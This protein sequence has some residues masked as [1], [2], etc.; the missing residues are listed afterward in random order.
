LN[1][2]KE[3]KNPNFRKKPGKLEN[4]QA[5][6]HFTYEPKFNLDLNK[7]NL[8]AYYNKNKN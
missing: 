7:V 6:S 3:V 2:L 1:F 8:N 4:S 5:H